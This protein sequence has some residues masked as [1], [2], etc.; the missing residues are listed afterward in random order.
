MSSS[1]ERR[2][3]NFF[4]YADFASEYRAAGSDP[5]LLEPAFNDPTLRGTNFVIVHGG[6]M[7]APH[8]NAY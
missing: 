5:L 1:Q 3:T 2:R 4:D 8:A 6:G 7:Y